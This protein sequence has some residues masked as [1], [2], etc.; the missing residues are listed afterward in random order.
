MDIILFCM[1]TAACQLKQTSVDVNIEKESIELTS[2]TDTM[3]ESLEPI[4]NNEQS[5]RFF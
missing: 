1:I 3:V 4:Q 5:N 2:E